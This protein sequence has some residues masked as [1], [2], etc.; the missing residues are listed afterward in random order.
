[1]AFNDDFDGESVFDFSGTAP[2]G[3]DY[4][5]DN[6]SETLDHAMPD[7]LE[8]EPDMVR[9]DLE[10]WLGGMELEELLRELRDGGSRAD[11]DDVIDMLRMRGWLEDG[12]LKSVMLQGC[13]L[14][15]VDLVDAILSDADMDE[16]DLSGADLEAA[17]LT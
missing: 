11:A 6:K 3:D 13:I 2:T 9:Q 7:D 15:E 5:D 10:E 14:R 1:M 12:S 17:D 16:V 8:H 4:R